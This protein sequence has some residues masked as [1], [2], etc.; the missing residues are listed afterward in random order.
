MKIFFVSILLL[1]PGLSLASGN[2]EI[3][4]PL[5][6]SDLVKVSHEIDSLS[7]AIMSCIDSGK[8]HKDCMCANKQ[9]FAHFTD[10]VN[11]L[12]KTYPQ[13]EGQDLINFKNTEG[14]L[15][16]LSLEGIKKQAGTEL[17]CDQ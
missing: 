13:L 17:S 10:T 2:L 12:F 16:N 7:S 15:I 4:A 9:L 1:I 11:T 14:M 3:K 6:V 5:M 8:E